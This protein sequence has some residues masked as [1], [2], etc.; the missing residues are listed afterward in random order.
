MI[1]RQEYDNKN[2]YIRRLCLAAGLLLVALLQNTVGLLP[3]A[4]GIRAMPLIPAAVC[5]AMFERE[6]PGM[7]YGVFAGLLWDGTSA[8]GGNF[9]AV[10]LTIVAF[11]C[12]VLITHVMRNNFLTAIL[13]SAGALFLYESCCFVRDIVIG[14]HLDAAYKILT[15]YI[16]SGLY[17]L[18]F[19]PVLYFPIRALEKRFADR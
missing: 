1:V 6:L 8:S 9:H 14:G 10:L 16:P 5:V 15:F 17:S 4:F 18:L 7:F 3:S 11:T 2:I 13:L 12:G 19:L